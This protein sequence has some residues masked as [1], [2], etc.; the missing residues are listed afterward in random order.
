M[1]IERGVGNRVLDRTLLYTAVTR[2]QQQ[3]IIVGDLKAAPRA[4]AVLPKAA[5]RRVALTQMLS[6]TL[7]KMT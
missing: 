4:T 6:D 2:A 5:A 1:F 7:T 3:V